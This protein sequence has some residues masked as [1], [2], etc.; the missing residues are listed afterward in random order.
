MLFQSQ[1]T[2]LKHWSPAWQRKKIKENIRAILTQKRR[3]LT[4]EQVAEYSAAIRE[5]LEG[6]PEWQNAQTVL[7]YYPI[8]GEVDT[9]PLLEAWKNEKTMLLP[10][11]HRS[12]LE[13]RKYIDHD[14]LRAGRFRIPEPQGEAYIGKVDLI[15][16]PGVAFDRKRNRLGRGGGY[17]DRFLKRYTNIPHVAV[18]YD[19]QIIKEIPTTIF[20]RKVT[21]IVTPTEIIK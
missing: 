1:I 13:M 18:A 11:A 10:I 20:D 2:A 21:H 7:L 17:Y 4:K 6:M 5:R 15:I 9:R 14:N 12:T 19:F 16:V 3:I 8:H